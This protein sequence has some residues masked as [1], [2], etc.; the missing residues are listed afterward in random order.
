MWNRAQLKEKAKFALKHNYWK[1]ILVS[2]M[3]AIVVG[4]SSGV[5]FDLTEEIEAFLEEDTMSDLEYSSQYDDDDN[6]EEYWEGYYDGYFGDENEYSSRDYADGYNDG[7][8]DKDVESTV[9]WGGILDYAE[10]SPAYAIGVGIVIVGIVVVLCMFVLVISFVWSAFIYNPL[11]MGCN[12]FFF[13]T[14][15]Q[16]AEVK[17]VAFAFDHNYKN[18]IKIL[19]FRTLYTTLWGLL[20]WIPGII[21]SYEY[22]MIPYLLAENPNLTKEQAFAMSKQMMSGNKWSAFVLDLSFLG[23]DLLSICTLGI[24]GT[25]YV[26][27]YENLTNAALYEELSLIHGRPAFAAKQSNMEDSYLYEQQMQQENTYQEMNPYV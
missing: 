2:M 5:S 22:R 24:L 23:W 9:S 8:L 12:R 14:L 18:V 19:F 25:F 4:S 7:L 15:N 21:K 11:E 16:K 1:T 20:F 27:P 13:I 3:L 10:E 26:A 17:E 6:S